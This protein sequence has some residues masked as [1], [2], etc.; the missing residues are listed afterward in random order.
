MADTLRDAYQLFNKRRYPEVIRILESQVFRF[1]DDFNFYYILGMSC[2][3]QGDFGGAFSYLRRAFDLKEDDVNTLLGIAAI[4]LKR[5]DTGNA[6]RI[7]LDVTEMDP[8]NIYAERGLNYLRK[9]DNPDELTGVLSL[10]RIIRFLPQPGGRKPRFRPVF[11]L[12][13]AAAA[14]IVLLALPFTRT[15][16]FNAVEKTG[17]L[18]LGDPK[19]KRPEIPDVSLDARKDF[20]DLSGS[21][22]YILT[23]K[24]VEDKLREIQDYLYD[25]RDNLAQ[26]EIN[27]ILL[28]NSSEYVKN[29][30]RLL[31]EYIQ[32]PGLADFSDNFSYSEVVSEPALYDGCYVLWK[33]KATNLEETPEKISFDFLVGYHDNKVLDGIVPVSFGFAIKIIPDQPMEL[34]GKVLIGESG[35]ALEGEAIHLL[36]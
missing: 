5:G 35:P 17:I 36:K 3:Y 18:S 22:T 7:W 24:E 28:S 10:D 32:T 25:F 33:G 26:R 14:V 11:I 19:S 6:L 13:P 15:A 29:R 23:E 31:A 2:L 16:L 4:Y 34:L 1:R 8:G 21:S 20:I 30:A 9:S 27:R 12:I